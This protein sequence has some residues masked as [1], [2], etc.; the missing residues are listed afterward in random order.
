MPLKRKYHK[1]IAIIPS[2]SGI[3]N[4]R[5]L[6]T[7]FLVLFTSAH[8][9]FAQ[10]LKYGHWHAA[11]T[12]YNPAFAG[13]SGQ[14]RMILNFRDQWPVMPQSYVSYRAAFDGYVEPIRSGIG[15][16][17][18]QDNQGDGVLQSTDFGL[19]YMYQ[20]RLGYSWALNFGLQGSYQQ[21]RLNWLDLQFLDQI[22]LL[23]GFNDIFGNPNPSSEPVPD[24]LTTGFT[25]LG[26]GAVLYSD[27]LYVG[28]SAAHV[29]TPKV[30][31]YN[32]A[33]SELPMAFSGQAGVF[34][35]GERKD[36][37]VFNPYV[38][39]TTQK[40]F[41]Q[42]QSGAYVKKSIVLAGFAIKHNTSNLS[43]VV[44]LAGLS[45]GMLKFAYSYDISVGPLAGLSGGSHEV[46]LMLT[47]KDNEGR[48]KKNS[49]KSMLD[50]PSIL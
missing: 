40:G 31:F 32:N 29:N 36:D 5:V 4:L 9:L 26:A 25:D 11:E 28:F 13:S 8:Q 1:N 3:V 35:G 20:A 45:K 43:D 24:R 2:F 23:Y 17:I 16:Y 18:N 14:P 37:L 33:A 47:L 41:S 27:R 6:T 15:V 22:N 7:C 48:T 21:Y 10:D 44:F 46:S 19:Q 30:S 12:N 34:F 49:Q 50:C 38:L 39:Y 42:L